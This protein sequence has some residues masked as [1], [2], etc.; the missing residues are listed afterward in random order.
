MNRFFLLLLTFIIS[1]GYGYAQ[2]GDYIPLLGKHKAGWYQY[3]DLPEVS[4]VTTFTVYTEGDTTV[5]GKT[6][7][8]FMND[9]YIAD[10][11]SSYTQ[12]LGYY[13]EDVSERKVY[14][15]NSS[16]ST[17]VEK[18]VYDFSK[19]EGDTIHVGVNGRL[20]V[21]E[22]SNE[23]N[24]CGESIELGARV[25]YLTNLN[26]DEEVIWIEGIGSIAGFNAN[27]YSI[28]CNNPMEVLI[29]KMSDDEILYHYS[30]VEGYNDCPFEV[31]SSS[32]KT[33][34]ALSLKLYP[35]PVHSTL[36]ISGNPAE[37]GNASYRIFNLTGQEMKRG[38]LDY[39]SE[40][41]IDVSALRSGAYIMEI[42]N[43]EKNMMSNK[44]FIIAK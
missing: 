32:Q 19:D 35:N 20:L 12:R 7:L 25:F 24:I 23:L 4:G 8:R 6:Y 36:R 37:I 15:L 9:W 11:D 38:V 28:N 33:P 34:E 41:Q 27:D 29:C 44:K 1:A 42:Y 2:D 21:E 40:A 18:V 10:D 16:T 3:V 17:E 5:N 31:G 39:S 13:R 43:K 22:I 14:S 30:G 26:S